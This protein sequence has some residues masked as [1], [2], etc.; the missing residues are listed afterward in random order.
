[1]TEFLDAASTIPVPGFYFSEGFERYFR[2]YKCAQGAHSALRQVL[3]LFW[4]SPVCQAIWSLGLLGGQPWG[5]QG[6]AK[7][8]RVGYT[9]SQRAFEG[10]QPPL[11]RPLNSP[12]GSPPCQTP[13]ATSHPEDPGPPGQGLA[14]PW[15]LILGPSLRG[16]A[17][18][19]LC[20]PLP[21]RGGDFPG[22]R[23]HLAFDSSQ[24]LV[25]IVRWPWRPGSATGPVMWRWRSPAEGGRWQLTQPPNSSPKVCPS[26]QGTVPS[27]PKQEPRT[28]CS[29]RP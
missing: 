9:G 24:S 21:S 22:V 28:G 3:S 11:F 16:R 20:S 25:L 5:A 13:W 27:S 6:C 8:V 29:V 7:R 23:G 17:G 12:P 2:S 14:G 18:T 19:F 10:H 26:V 15:C 1:V 4:P